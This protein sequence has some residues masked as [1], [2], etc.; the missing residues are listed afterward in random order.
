MKKYFS[1]SPSFKKFVR[2]SSAFFATSAFS[3]SNVAFADVEGIPSNRDFPNAQYPYAQAP[4]GCSGPWGTSEVRDSWGPV[5]FTGACDNHDRCYYTSGSKWNTCNERFYSDL[6]TACERDLRIPI[7]RPDPSLS[8]PLRTKV[9]GY[10]PPEP[11]SLA[12]CYRLATDYYTG[13]QAGVAL[14]VFNEAQNKQRRYEEWVASVRNP[15]GVRI[16]VNSGNTLVYNRDS[17][18]CTFIAS[19]GGVVQRLTSCRHSWHSIVYTAD[20]LL[21]YDRGAGDIE[22]YAVSGQGLGVRLHGYGPGSMR[23]TWAQITSPRTGIVVFKDDNGQVETY[24]L[25]NIGML[26][27]L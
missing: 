27:P 11:A 21:F 17:G 24:R 12:T 13:V 22:T 26:E 2:L 3:Y 15:T 20:K 9:V 8:D 10:L 6:R 23:K 1:S 7:R 16:P 19:N 4:N 25:N 18:V 14:N 5:N